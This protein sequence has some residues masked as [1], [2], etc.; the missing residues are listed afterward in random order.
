MGQI[1]W[2]KRDPSAALATMRELSLEEN[3]AYSTILEVWRVRDFIILDDDQFLAR[4]LNV[5]IR[6]WKRIRRSL[7]NSRFLRI[8]DGHLTPLHTFES[9][10]VRAAIPMAVRRAV[11]ERDGNECRY[12]GD[13]SGPFEFDHVLPWSRGG[14][15][16]VEN[17]VRACAP[18]NREKS[19]RTP[20]EMEWAL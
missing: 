1:K 11:I 16:T 10:L 3:G 9:R 12:C 19:D 15:D 5:D 17:I 14:Q 18:C 2:Y 20:D 4:T 6:V 7:I 8:D 13:T